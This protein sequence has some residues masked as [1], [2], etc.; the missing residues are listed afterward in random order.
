MEKALTKMTNEMTATVQT[1]TESVERR[2]ED[3]TQEMRYFQQV[4]TEQI[5]AFHDSDVQL[6]RP[7]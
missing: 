5:Q 3:H 2:M 4:V 1:V 6:C 7:P